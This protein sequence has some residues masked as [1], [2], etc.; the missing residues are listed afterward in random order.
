ML[1]TTTLL[2]RKD[3]ILK[4]NYS[5]SNKTIEYIITCKDKYGREHK[6][7]VLPSYF[8]ETLILERGNPYA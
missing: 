4:I 7:E 5:S 1:S 6:I 8:K 3:K 2:L